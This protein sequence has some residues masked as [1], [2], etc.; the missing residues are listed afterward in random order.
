MGEGLYFGMIDFRTGDRRV[1]VTWGGDDLTWEGVGPQ[2][3]WEAP[4]AE[5]A[6]ALIRLDERLS[7]PTS[8][9]PASAWV[10][11]EPTAFV[12][13][14]YSVC[15][16]GKEGI[17]RT[18]IL[19]LLPPAAGDL[20]RTQEFTRG[21]YTNNLGTFVLW[22][23]ELTSEDARILER[24]LDDAGLRGTKT[25]FGLSYGAVE[26]HDPGAVADFSLMVNPKLPDG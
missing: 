13:S 12:P 23:S 2:A 3:P 11:S 22:C 7:D 1:H 19:A 20:L 9:L 4:T 26:I 17:G 21:E 15:Y 5:Q 14:E 16:E 18:G 24:I 25:V 10:S 8:W 6:S